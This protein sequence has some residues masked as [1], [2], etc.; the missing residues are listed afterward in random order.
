MA[1]TTRRK[2][3]LRFLAGAAL[4]VCGLTLA[5]CSTG[6]ATRSPQEPNIVQELSFW[7]PYLLYILAAPHSRLYV[8]IDAVEGCAPSDRTLGK[9]RD[10]LATYCDKP[11]GIEIARSD[12]IPVAAARGIPPK[13]LARKYLNGPP[14]D[15]KAPTPAFMYVLYYSGALSDEYA[16][17]QAG[18]ADQKATPRPRQRDVH[19]HADLLPY[20]AII[21]M[22]TNYMRNWDREQVLP[23]E[24]GHLLGLA[25]R[26]TH[27]S[28]YHCLEPTCL[29]N[30]YFHFHRFLLGLQKRLCKRCVTQLADSSRQPPPSNLR[31]A[32]PVLVRSENGYHILSLPRRM[33][34]MV[35]DLT[36]QDCRDFAAGVH[37]EAPSP[38][39]DNDEFL[40][41]GQVKQDVLDDPARMRDV[42][43]RIKNDPYE[44][45]RVAAARIQNE[46][47]PASTH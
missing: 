24:A 6:K 38:G 36:E 1:S 42:L 2:E 43:N 33:R 15:A 34:I 20:P 18:A 26:L 5:G 7:Q 27:A 23:H 30:K 22:N 28:G 14:E 35:G 47:E 39:S 37:A 12:V 46:V 4:L 41:E 21:F 10:F 29:M 11:G 31:F 40:W 16:G 17:S 8:E 45:V 32:G 25:G 44:V 9:L 13:P 19:C 3:T